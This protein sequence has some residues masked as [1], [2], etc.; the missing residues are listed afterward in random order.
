MLAFFD[1]D[2]PLFPPD[3]IEDVRLEGPKSTGKLVLRG[4]PRTPWASR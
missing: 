3:Q 2:W 4:G 1:A